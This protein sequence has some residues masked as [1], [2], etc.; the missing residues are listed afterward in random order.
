VKNFFLL[1]AFLFSGFSLFS[2]VN[3]SVGVQKKGNKYFVKYQ[4]EAGET[5]YALSRKYAVTVAEIKEANPGVDITDIG[6]GQII[7]VPS[8]YTGT[9]TPVTPRNTSETQ[10][11]KVAAKETLYSLSRQYGISVEDLKQANPEVA[12][13]GLQIGMLLSIPGKGKTASAHKEK[14]V[15]KT[16]TIDKPIRVPEKEPTVPKKA[17]APAVLPTDNGRIEKIKETGVAEAAAAK[18]DAPDFYALHRTAP[19]GTIIQVVNEKSGENAYVRVIGKLPASASPSTLIQL[20][21]KAM[22]RLN[23]KSDK[24]NVALSYFLP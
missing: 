22:I 13:K 24:E 16:A 2:A 15:P 18:E 11:H 17:L 5:L 8:K 19:V 3:D 10:T 23:I 21:S 12:A 7:L 9:Q 20:S 6:I 4:M 14:E 1:F